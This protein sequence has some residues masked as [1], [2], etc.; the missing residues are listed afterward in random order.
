[1][2]KSTFSAQE[3]DLKVPLES[4][5]SLLENRSELFEMVLSLVTPEDINQIKPDNL[6]VSFQ[7]QSAL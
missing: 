6:R 7:N 5:S 1:M 2:D 4:L 3:L